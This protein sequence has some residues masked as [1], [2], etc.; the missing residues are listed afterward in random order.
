MLP[1][2]DLLAG[3]LDALARH[4]L[5]MLH[6]AALPSVSMLV[7]GEVVRGSWWGHRD[8]HAIFD[9][10]SALES[11]P[12]ALVTKLVCGK[13]T[14]VHRRLVPALL[15]VAEAR[16]RWQLDGL[17]PEAKALVTRVDEDGGVLASGDAAKLVE[18]RLLALGRQVHTP[19]GR[20]A[21][22]LLAWSR[23]ARSLD[24]TPLTS[25]GDARRELETAARGLGPTA[26][27]PWL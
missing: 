18:R 7:A 23:V 20:H 17:T 1:G 19:N 16:D 25:V 3:P 4:G 13:V 22:E 12:D 24:V 9:V 10:A 26:T 5:L 27:L 15:A 21:T 2:M 8:G 14:Y 11:H 6:D